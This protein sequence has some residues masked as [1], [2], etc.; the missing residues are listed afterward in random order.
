[1]ANHPLR[2]LVTVI[3]RHVLWVAVVL[4]MYMAGY[5]LREDLPGFRDALTDIAWTGFV[6]VPVVAVITA[7][8][9]LALGLLV[10]LR[11]AKPLGR[12]ARVSLATLTWVVVAAV[13][14]LPHPTS[15]VGEKL[16]G[17]LAAG[18]AGVVYGL[19]LPTPKSNQRRSL[20]MAEGERDKGGEAPY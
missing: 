3:F 13:A 14:V 15:T 10:W 4:G 6:A 16:A 11:R 2:Y 17:L 8:V 12:L 18:L 20:P 5:L 1:V 7:P 19:L 9:N